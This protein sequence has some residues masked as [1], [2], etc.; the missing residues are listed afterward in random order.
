[1][2]DPENCTNSKQNIP[3]VFHTRRTLRDFCLLELALLQDFSGSLVV[4]V[5]ELYCVLPAGD[6]D[7]IS[8]PQN[9][10]PSI[11]PS[12]QSLFSSSEALEPE[13]LQWWIIP[14]L[15]KLNLLSA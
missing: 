9:T 4:P 6:I 11:P 5:L 15:V 3:L 13:L 8:K 2:S 10:D 7:E 14:T 12:L 1:M